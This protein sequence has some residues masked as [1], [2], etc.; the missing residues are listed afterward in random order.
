MIESQRR[1]LFFVNGSQSSAAAVRAQLFANRFDNN[2]ETNY[3]RIKND[4]KD[5]KK[6][7]KSKK[8][9]GKKRKDEVELEKT[10]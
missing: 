7:K 2:W 9:K 4:K 1:L 10:K 6:D 3:K 5:K 8:D